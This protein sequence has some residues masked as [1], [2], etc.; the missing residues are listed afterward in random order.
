MP[1]IELTTTIE[2]P[3]HRVFDLARSIELHTSTT[4]NTGEHAIAGVTSGLIGADQ[5]VTW[6]ANHF[7]VW[8]NLSVRVTAFQ[9]PTHF[10]DVMVRG[11]FKRM[12]HD[13]FFESIE[14]G[15]RMRDVFS[16]EAPLWIFGRIAESL[17]LT[18]Y[19]R[20]FLVKRNQELKATAE[21]DS[22]RQYLKDT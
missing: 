21:S 6:R 5:E 12:K 10:A 9:R 3:I 2:A 8:Q 16:F 1:V 7:G 22:W 14:C 4:S 15:T 17:F 18:N 13:H 11:A 20:V 19:M